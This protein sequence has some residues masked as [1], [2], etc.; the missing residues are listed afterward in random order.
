MLRELIATDVFKLLLVFARLGAAMMLLPGFSSTVVNARTRLLL[1]LGIAFLLMPVLGRSLPPA[2]AGPLSLFLLLGGEVTIG[3]FLGLMTQILMAPLDLAG[4]VISNSVGLTNVFT[5]D[6]VS[7]QQSQLLPGFLNLIAV[8][9]VF[10]TDSHHLMLRAL[11]DSYGLFVPGR[12]LPMDDFAAA[13]VRTLGE[14]FVLG[15]KLAAP[16][17]VFSLTLNTALALLNRLVPQMQVFFVG[18]PI[19]LLGGLAILMLCL[20]PIM[21]WFIRNFVDGVGAFLS[22]G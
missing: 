16:A 2:P 21:Y 22:R 17:L 1:A 5:F 3:I 6:P 19:Q 20:P 12:P 7:R 4:T 13:L 11:V 18:L 8:T 14:S 15:F 9:L 10:L